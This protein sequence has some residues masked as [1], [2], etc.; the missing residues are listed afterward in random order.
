MA[1]PFVDD[2]DL[3]WQTES[4]IQAKKDYIGVGMQ[5]LF[6]DPSMNGA[7]PD[8]LRPDMLYHN[9][10][11]GHQ[12]FQN[13]VSA[14]T[15]N[16]MFE[17]FYAE[18]SHKIWIRSALLDDKLTTGDLEV[19]LPG[20]SK[21]YGAEQPVDILMVYH[22]CEN[23]TILSET[24][25]FRMIS[26]LDVQVH[27]HTADGNVEYAA[28][29]NLDNV[30][31][32]YEA[33]TENMTLALQLTQLN[34]G[35]V[36]VLECSWGK[37]SAASIKLKINNGFRVA[38]PILN[39][40]LLAHRI[41]F[42]THLWGLFDLKDLNL[43]YFEDYVLFG[44]TPV[45]HPVKKSELPFY[46]EYL[47]IPEVGPARDIDVFAFDELFNPD[48]FTETFEVIDGEEYLTIEPRQIR[49]VQA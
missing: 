44:I 46:H 27:V 35:K 36:T 18:R 30:K 19:I 12:K 47:E 13:Y 41:H 10:E 45:F 43:S 33:I 4:P 28:G 42:P 3:D 34:V 49:V 2:W 22:N 20:I 25:E 15:I 7:K 37:L 31:F 26:N 48:D 39:K 23:F 1:I 17:S 14:W 11:N 21:A 8:M 5:A 32:G 40:M 16:S 24:G 9:G 29:M 38:K 6:F